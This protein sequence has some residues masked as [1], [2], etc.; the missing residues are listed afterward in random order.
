MINIYFFYVIL[1]IYKKMYV[2]LLYIGGTMS[3]YKIK[4]SKISCSNCAATITKALSKE[5]ANTKVRVSVVANMVFVETESSLEDVYSILKSIGYPADEDIN[6]KINLRKYDLPISIILSIPLLYGMIAHIYGITFL[7]I[8][9]TPW[10][11]FIFATIIQFYIGRRYYIGAYNGLKKKVLGMDFLVIFSTT[12]SYLYSIYLLVRY[13]GHN[14]VYFE[15]AAIIITI[16]LI[17]KTI[18]ENAKERTNELLNKLEEL[19][20]SRITLEDGTVAHPTFVEV[21]TRYLVKTN[22]KIE[23]DGIL[24]SA[25]AN[26]DESII[27]GESNSIT[28]SVGDDVIGGTLNVGSNIIVETSKLAEDNYIYQIINKIEEAS[29]IDTKFQKIADRVAM[30][31]VPFIILI[32]ILTFA[33][34]YYLNGDFTTS[35]EHA[36]AVIVISCPCSLGLATPTSIMVSNSISA[37]LGILYKGAKFFELANKINILAFDKTGTLTTGKMEVVELSLDEEYLQLLYTI[38]SH[39]QHPISKAICNYLNLDADELIE[40]IQIPGIGLSTT[41]QGSSY[42]VANK[43]ILK[44]SQSIAMIEKLESK[45]LTVTVVV[46][47]GEMIGYYAMRDKIKDESK[48]VIANLNKLGI[49]PYL[50]SGDNLQVVKYVAEELGINNYYAKC[51]PEQKVDILKQLKSDG[52]IIGFVGD[53][54]NDSIGLKYADVG[55]GVSEG[56]DIATAAS[57]VILL[58]DDLRLVIEGI[59]LS[60]LTHKNIIHNFIWAF[61]YNLI[62]IPLA[63]TGRLNMIWAA[64]FMGFSSIIVVLNALNLKRKYRR[65]NDTE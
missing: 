45:A 61:S 53:G 17:G 19:T 49:Q 46:K 9:I 16:V 27:S 13:N 62:A 30:Y 29:L 57:D 34:T 1:T 50:I 37:K 63:A 24:V 54:V 6:S 58:K 32:G 12:F 65:L 23:M 7:H 11:Q 51:S 38:E 18:E 36:M 31:F 39:S 42:Q 43:Q 48:D 64:I 44:D 40:V 25:I 26:L 33:I 56:S 28:K 47:N 14:E 8:I 5:L 22:Q 4:V 41:Y 60:T 59:K 55:I 15:V 21:G 52:S 3:I 20:P 10:A 2:T 35:F